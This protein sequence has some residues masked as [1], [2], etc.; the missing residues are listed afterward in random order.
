M[1]YKTER[2]HEKSSRLNNTENESLTQ[3][4]DNENG[5]VSNNLNE[6]PKII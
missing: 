1:N 4:I 6:K 2:P 3:L 5:L